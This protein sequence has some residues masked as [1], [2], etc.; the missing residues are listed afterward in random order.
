MGHMLAGHMVG[1]GQTWMT[2]SK[3]VGSW[4]HLIGDAM[5]KGSILVL[6]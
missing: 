2:Q 4:I 1:I 3:M 6:V 5:A